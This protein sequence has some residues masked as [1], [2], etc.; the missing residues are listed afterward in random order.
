MNKLNRNQEKNAIIQHAVD[1]SI[2]QEIN[3]VS[4]ED[5]L[6]D[7]MYYEFRKD[8]LYEIDNTSLDK[9]TEKIE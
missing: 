5:E 7:N 8:Y 4:A 6:N 1:E 2:L 3:K 9:K